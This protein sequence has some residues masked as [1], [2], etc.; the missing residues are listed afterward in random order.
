MFDGGEEFFGVIG[1]FIDLIDF[2]LFESLDV[3]GGIFVDILDVV[4]GEGLFVF[5]NDVLFNVIVTVESDG[6]V[7]DAGSAAH[8]DNNNYRVKS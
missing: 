7:S 8:K 6:P 3:A 5:L 4:F 1:G 2:F